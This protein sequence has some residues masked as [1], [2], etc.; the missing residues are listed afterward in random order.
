M[1]GLKVVVLAGLALGAG[2]VARAE[3]LVYVSKRPGEKVAPP[4][5]KGKIEEE[6]PYGIKIKPPGKKAKVELVPAAQILKVMYDTEPVMARL[7]F[8]R[9]FNAEDQAL[10][11]EAALAKAKTDKERAR[12]RAKRDALLE[13]A[14]KG[15]RDLEGKLAGS[16]H[17][18]RHVRYKIAHVLVLQARDE[19]REKVGAAI[20]ALKAFAAD[21]SSGWQ[22]V[23]ALRTLGK[24]QE[25]AGKT[26]DARKTY[27]ALSEVPDVPADVKQESEVLVARLYLRGKKYPEAEKKLAA[28]EGSLPA[29]DAMRAYV[30][31]YRAES[32]LGQ[33]NLKPVEKQLQA[34]LRATSDDRVRAL[35]HN[36]LGDYY[37]RQG[38]NE[39]AFWQY[40]RVDVVYNQD[41]EEHAKALYY[42]SKLFDQV[43]GQP[44]RAKECAARLAEPL[45]AGTLY[46]RLANEK[47]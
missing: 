44:A 41:P 26:D 16:P 42:L 33:G 23:G 29:G 43:K 35:A 2:V 7:D 27:E 25:K 24:L 6:G 36:L 20:E 13:T 34:A 4:P 10:D 3:D 21:N 40:L 31:V 45:F 39:E 22:I 19:D 32:Q 37:W 12:A 14:L 5:M 46:Q 15:Y 17:A 30:M 9:P 11:M 1:K 47:K 18:R 38:K 8:R 28:L